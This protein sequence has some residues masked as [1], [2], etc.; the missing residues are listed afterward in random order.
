MEKKSKVIRYRRSTPVGRLRRNAT[1]IARHA[2]LVKTRLISWGPI[3][4]KRISLVKELVEEILVK[5][6]TIDRRLGELERNGFVVPKRSSAIFFE[7]GQMVSIVPKHRRKYR[8]VFAEILKTD[9][10]MLDGLTVKSTLPSG[11]VVIQRGQCTPF[12][13]SKSHLLKIET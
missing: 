4:D 10:R 2:T 11:E 1:K 7:Q 12:L 5:V 13:V 8:I 9:P 6:T 3:A